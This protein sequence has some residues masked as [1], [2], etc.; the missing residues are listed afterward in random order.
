MLQL[1]T[2]RKKAIRCAEILL[3]QFAL[4][5]RYSATA[6]Q[7]EEAERDV[8]QL[9]R[10]FGRFCSPVTDHLIGQKSHHAN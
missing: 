5:G 4:S 3:T 9:E 2:G 7:I 8:G 1:A 10:D 6:F